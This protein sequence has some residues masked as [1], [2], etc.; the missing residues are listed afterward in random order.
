MNLKTIR[1]MI[2]YHVGH[3]KEKYMKKKLLKCV[4]FL[5]T[6]AIELSFITYTYFY[7]MLKITNFYI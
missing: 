1:H 4:N 2:I 6:Q 5:P 3:D 7:F